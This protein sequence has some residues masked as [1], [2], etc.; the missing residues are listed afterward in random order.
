MPSAWALEIELGNSYYSLNHNYANWR[1]VYLDILEKTV[2][3][4]T[5]YS[6]IRE[7]ERF[8][9]K[10]QQ[11]VAGIYSPLGNQWITL[12]EA[13]L[14]SSHRVLPHWSVLLQVQRTFDQGWVTHIGMRRTK[15]Q[16]ASVIHT[17]I[18]NITLERYIGNYRFAYSFY[19]NRVDEGGSSISHA[20]QANYYY[21]DHDSI[22]VIYAF[23]KDI[24]NIPPVPPTYYDVHSIVLSGRHWFTS[25][26]ALSHEITLDRQGN[27]YS[28]K[29]FRLGIRYLF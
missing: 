15:Y 4:K 1:S 10:D 23:G 18:G 9:F 24:Q 19:A 7:T 3:G 17:N 22:G 13:S 16:N 26:L 20:L 21:G 12:F 8:S 27:L 11:V 28:R 29:G 6:N 25:R 14:S 5:I 2:S